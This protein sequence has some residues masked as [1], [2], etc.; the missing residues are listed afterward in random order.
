MIDIAHTRTDPA[1]LVNAAVDAL[2]RHR[3]E[4]PSLNTLTRLAG[5]VHSL[6][7][8]AQWQRI[9]ASLKEDERAALEALLVVDPTT[10]ESPFAVICRAPG[11]ATRK[12]LNTLI[13]RHQ[14]LQELPHPTSALEP[15]ADAKVLLWANEAR[16]LKAPQL[17][18]YIA[19]R[20]HALLLAVLR[21]ARGQLLDEHTQMLLKLVRKIEWKS[22]Q[23]LDE[24]YQ[25]RRATTD[26]LIR[27]FHESLIVHNSDDQPARKVERL[28]TLFTAHGG[29]EKLK[30]SC[31]QHLRHERQNWRPFARG[32][33]E[34]LRSPLLR[35][36]D[37]LPLQATA[38]TN[39]LLGLV[40]AVIG[41]EPPY[42][43]YLQINDFGEEVL[44][45]GWRGLVLDDPDDRKAFNRRQLEV[46]AMLELAAAI[47]AGE[48]FVSGSLSFDRF[49]D[50]LP[51]EAAGPAAIAAYAASQGW[52]EGAEGFIG[53]VK[54]SLER[55]EGFLKGALSEGKEG[56]LRRG[57]DGRPIVTPPQAVPTPQSAIELEKL[58]TERMPE[59]QL[60]SA[61][62]NSE[63][64]TQSGAAILVPRRA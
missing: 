10:Q 4:L 6:V 57:K 49:W 51:R 8:T 9:G 16:R 31:A 30:E 20:R 14:W 7:N 29:R 12:N 46:V 54:E 5:R 41:D 40:T 59:R 45:R 19:P 17:R 33:F 36:A 26:S 60:L 28:E 58:L 18:E 50:R 1:D 13:D 48:M 24:W 21:Q 61:I 35:V 27:A 53:S 63:H 43:D 11:R 52:G 39:D 15:I 38:A 64:W 42:S 3:F 47:K 62:A 22:E 44:P 34:R 37:I 32:A 55:Q 56:Y 25:G 2:V 23:Q